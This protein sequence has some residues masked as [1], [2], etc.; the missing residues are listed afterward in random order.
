MHVAFFME[1]Q[2]NLILC[3]KPQLPEDILEALKTEQTSS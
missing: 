3:A 2:L 1:N